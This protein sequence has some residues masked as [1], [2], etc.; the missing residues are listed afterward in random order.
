MKVLPREYG[1]QYSWSFI[2]QKG[3]W[4]KKKVVKHCSSSSDIN[5]ADKISESKGNFPGKY[6]VKPAIEAISLDMKQQELDGRFVLFNTR[7]S[8]MI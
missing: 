7:V 1:L 5:I 2:F 3:F 6:T 8:V 4:G